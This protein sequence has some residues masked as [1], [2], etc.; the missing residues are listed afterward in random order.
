LV[1]FGIIMTCVLVLDSD[2]IARQLFPSYTLAKHINVGRIVTRIEVL[3]AA[4][5]L[6]AVYFKLMLYFYAGMIGLAHLLKIKHA[7]MLTY[8]LVSVLMPLS[9]VI[10]PNLIF[11]ESFDLRVW[12][13]L[14]VL[15]GL[16]LPLVL[17]M[18][19]GIRKWLTHRR[20]PLESK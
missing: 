7:G 18:A 9:L 16:V 17:V 19:G 12:P 13:I 5:W 8:P 1:L 10:Y 20:Q 3:M 4:I 6:I 2:Q 15:L 11:R 14:A